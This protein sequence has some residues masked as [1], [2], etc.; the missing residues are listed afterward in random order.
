MPVL[1]APP[2]PT[3]V[4]APAPPERPRLT[5]RLVARRAGK[6]VAICA[7]GYVALWLLAVLGTLGVSFLAK[8]QY[9]SGERVAGIN[10]FLQVDDRLWRGSAPGPDGY[11]E[12]ADRG[13]ATVIDLRAEDLSE[14]QLA[15]P[16]EAGLDVVRMP[17]RD[18]Q[19]PTSEE[20]ALFTATVESSPGPVFVHC[21]AG[22][23][24]TGSITAA[25][26]VRT[27]QA[28]SGEAALRTLAVGPPSLEQVY[29][30]LT[31]D[32][33]EANQP[34][35]AVRAVSRLMDAPRRI[36]ASLSLF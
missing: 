20:V 24:R 22:V 11:E 26:L 15:L 30:V 17:I 13:V 9:S 19:T 7:I 29:Y 32:P 23:G 31:A 25:Y 14:R 16:G 10:H 8:Q 3:P 36:N 18:G 4:L 35:S 12:L 27:D 1:S 5:P 2:A 33:E 28:D 34:P 6:A 21:G